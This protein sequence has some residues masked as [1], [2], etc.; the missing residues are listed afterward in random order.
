MLRRR[1]EMKRRL[2]TALAILLGV[3]AFPIHSFA[4]G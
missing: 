4:Q 3:T 2:L 1:A